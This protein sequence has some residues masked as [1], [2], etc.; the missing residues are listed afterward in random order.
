MQSLAALMEWLQATP[1]AVFIHERPWLFTTIE[2]IHVFAISLVIGTI[3]IVDLRLLGFASAKRPFA[4]LAGQVLPLTWVAFVLAA[5]AGS[6]LFI[7]RATD[8]Y[9]STTFQIK[10]ALIVLAG[11]NMLIFE[12]ITMRG[13]QQWNLARRPPLSARLAGGISLACWALVVVFGRWTGFNV[14]PQ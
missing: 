8:Y 13:V 14:L 12:L 7:S 2:V 3:A 5:L 11:I 4:E 6:L 10:M 9:V 1:L